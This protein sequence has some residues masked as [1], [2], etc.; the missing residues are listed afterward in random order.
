MPVRRSAVRAVGKG[1]A[2]AASGVVA[3]T[4]ATGIVMSPEPAPSARLGGVH[5]DLQR[6]VQLRQI[7]PEQAALFEAK[8]E[9]EILGSG[10]SDATET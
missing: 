1:V 6:A 3:A 5:E 8:I 7:T 2:A 9:R 10:A 4:L